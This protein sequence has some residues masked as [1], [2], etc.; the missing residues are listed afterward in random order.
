MKR[1]MFAVLLLVV[2][3]GA[4]A[5]TVITID[6][7]E[8]KSGETKTLTDGGKTITIRRDGES[9]DIRIDGAGG[10]KKVTIS[11]DGDHFTIRPRVEA[12]EL[13][14]KGKIWIDGHEIPAFRPRAFKAPTQTWYVCPKD[15]A[16]LRVP[17][18]SKEDATYKCPVD[19]TVMEKRK[20]LGFQYFFSE[21]VEPESL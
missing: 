2:A 8:M 19:G 10:S 4:V 18:G 13:G 11:R 3:F 12:F 17:E 20:G 5:S 9:L 6:P 14:P 16:T 15:H 21:G 1:L 7:S